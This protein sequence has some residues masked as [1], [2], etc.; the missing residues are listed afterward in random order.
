MFKMP[1]GTKY[2]TKMVEGD[3]YNQ[4]ID[5]KCTQDPQG[6]APSFQPFYD[7][8]IN[9]FPECVFFRKYSVYCGYESAQRV[10]CI[11]SSDCVH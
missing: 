9:P 6:G 7:H 2:Y 10:E 5:M 11:I 4:T 1:N 8:L 3:M